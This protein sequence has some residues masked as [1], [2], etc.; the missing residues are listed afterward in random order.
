MESFGA[1][2][3]SFLSTDSGEVLSGGPQRVLHQHREYPR[4][5]RIQTFFDP[6]LDVPG[7]RDMAGSLELHR[8][9][10]DESL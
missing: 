6:P 3:R 7:C 2:L 1:M 5:P 9:K 10:D 8:L 4:L